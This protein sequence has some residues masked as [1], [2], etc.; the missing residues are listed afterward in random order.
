MPYNPY[1]AVGD[2]SDFYA[3]RTTL[4][5][6]ASAKSHY[7]DNSQVGVPKDVP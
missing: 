4:V 7:K 3:S 2:E 6:G 1:M 5:G